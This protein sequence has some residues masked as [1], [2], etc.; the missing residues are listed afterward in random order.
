M[1]IEGTFAAIVAAA[2]A[3]DRCPSNRPIGPLDDAAFRK[4]VLDGKIRSEV[5]RHNYRVATILVGEHAGESTAPA[6]PGSKAYRINGRLITS[7]E[8]PV[9]PPD[10]RSRPAKMDDV[11]T[12]ITLPKMSWDRKK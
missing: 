9:L 12:G 1:D 6:A 2:I 3:G 10:G 4:L 5:Y 8:P 11:V 7:R